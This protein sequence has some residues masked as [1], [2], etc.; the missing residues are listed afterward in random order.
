[1]TWETSAIRKWLLHDFKKDAFS[2][3]EQ[4]LICSTHLITPVNPE[5]GTSGGDETDDNVFLLSIEEAR[6]YFA[7]DAD[8]V[9]GPTLRAT[10]GAAFSVDVNSGS[11]WWLRSSGQKANFAARVYPDGSIFVKGNVVDNLNGGV[12]PAMWIDISETTK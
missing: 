12:R 9:C 5:Y 6:K 3:S 11:Y 10:K 1:M 7:S 2:E 8:R 4:D